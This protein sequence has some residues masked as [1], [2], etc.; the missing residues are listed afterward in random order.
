MAPHNALRCAYVCLDIDGP[1]FFEYCEPNAPTSVFFFA[2]LI[3]GMA[4][5]ME[6]L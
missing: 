6:C 4:G 1:F 5:W 2:V 3:F